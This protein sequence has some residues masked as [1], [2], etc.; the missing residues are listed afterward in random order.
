[1]QAD[2]NLILFI[3]ARS[4]FDVVLIQMGLILSTPVGERG[5]RAPWTIFYKVYA[6][7]I[8]ATVQ[9]HSHNHLHND[10]GWRWHLNMC[11]DWHKFNIFLGLLN[12]LSL[13]VL[14]CLRPSRFF[15]T[16]MVQEGDTDPTSFGSY[17]QIKTVSVFFSHIHVYLLLA[18]ALY[19]TSYAEMEA[20]SL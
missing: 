11:Q 5:Q 6:V 20:Q 10:G 15:K 4:H 7:C 16:L 18:Q 19:L 17:R 3:D 1:M 2:A 12:F 8:L 14:F 13:L 9:V